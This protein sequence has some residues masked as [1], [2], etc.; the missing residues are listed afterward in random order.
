MLLLL[1]REFQALLLADQLLID[2]FEAGLSP[3]D[4]LTKHVG[5]RGHLIR[6]TDLEV[7]CLE[8]FL[9]LSPAGLFQLLRQLIE[10][11][12]QPLNQGLATL[13]R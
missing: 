2:L 5:E 4:L 6:E 12:P 11:A 10:F 9:V 1:Q 13:H 3:F 8:N 7:L